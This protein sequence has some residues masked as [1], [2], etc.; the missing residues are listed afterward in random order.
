MPV[1]QDCFYFIHNIDCGDNVFKYVK[2]PD[3]PQYY[4]Y[5]H[6]FDNFDNHKWPEDS[7]LVEL[8][9]NTYYHGDSKYGRS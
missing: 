4:N 6:F 2:R 1:L 7:S 5:L 8:E 3:H 9:Q